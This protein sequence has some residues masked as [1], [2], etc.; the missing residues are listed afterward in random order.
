MFVFLS[1]Q[2]SH[3]TL[4]KVQQTALLSGKLNTTFSYSSKI[5]V[6]LPLSVDIKRSKYKSEESEPAGR[7]QVSI[8]LS[9]L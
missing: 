7:V 8:V 9:Q 6:Y 4:I 2:V 3:Q 1:F 5:L